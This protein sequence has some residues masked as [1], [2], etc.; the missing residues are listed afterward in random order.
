MTQTSPDALTRR[1]KALIESEGPLPVSTYMQ[2]CLH[3]PKHGYYATRPGLG[4]DFRTAP[5][6]SQVFGELL[7]VWAAY[8]WQVMGR[9]D[10]CILAEL[11]PGRG[12]LMADA[13][14]ATRKVEGF[15]D[16]MQLVLVEASPVLRAA[17]AERLSGHSV[18]H[19]AGL[20][21]VPGGPAIFIANEFL[22]CLPARQ[23][24]R[25]DGGWFERKVSTGPDGKLC[26]GLSADRPP[27]EIASSIEEEIEFQPGL[28]RV[29]EVLAERRD[30]L[31]ALFIDYGTDGSGPGDTLRAYRSGQQVHPLEAPG[32]CDLTVDVDFARLSRLASAA[33]LDVA[34]PIGQGM[35]LG[36]LGIE[37]RM[38][39][40]IRKAPE[41]ADAIY[42]GVRELVEPDR[43]GQRFKAMCLSSPSLP[44][45]VGF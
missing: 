7:G 1:L 27:S 19:V 20:G 5:E 33:R 12:T 26:F 11:G 38:Q 14:K 25:A 35:F 34:G 13:L 21:D 6:T 44:A 17:Q 28:Q 23:F 22:D 2:L 43:M 8:E 32:A 36:Q 3:D 18:H 42:E 30:P 10:P 9:P 45:P 15:H 29:V 16:A 39:A 24:V 41:S 4:V 31:R 40:L 37:A